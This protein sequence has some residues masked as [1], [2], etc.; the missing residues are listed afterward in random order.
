MKTNEQCGGYHAKS[1]A[2]MSPVE[3]PHLETGAGDGGAGTGAGLADLTVSITCQQ[4]AVAEKQHLWFTACDVVYTVR[5]RKIYTAGQKI[6]GT[7]LTYIGPAPPVRWVTVRQHRPRHD[8]LHWR[9]YRY[10]IPRCRVS[11]DHNGR[12]EPA[13]FETDLGHL[14]G[15]TRSCGCLAKEISKRPHPWLRKPLSGIIGCYEFIQEL[16]VLRYSKSGW[17]RRFKGKALCCGRIC[18]VC[19]QTA[20]HSQRCNYCRIEAWHRKGMKAKRKKAEGFVGKWFVSGRRSI[21]YLGSNRHQW[22]C[23]HGHRGIST[24]CNIRNSACQTC[25]WDE[26]SQRTRDQVPIGKKRYSIRIIGCLPDGVTRSGRRRQLWLGHDED[27]G[28]TKAI[29]PRNWVHGL[30]KSFLSSLKRRR[31]LRE[32]R[33]KSES[34]RLKETLANKSRRNRK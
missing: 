13:V 24:I 3:G 4:V 9:T 16:P 11:C 21:A 27:N 15:N 28:I 20:K 5:T 30:T 2:W 1:N 25:A 22:E 12:D 32:L 18:E 31:L 34:V 23:R 14:Y 33:S 8:L 29:D 6:P 19:L 26:L 10:P 17:K 7:R